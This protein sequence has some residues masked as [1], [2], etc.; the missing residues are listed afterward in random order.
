LQEGAQVCH[1]ADPQVPPSLSIRG[2][3]PERLCGWGRTGRQTHGQPGHHAVCSVPPTGALCF[4]GSSTG[5]PKHQSAKHTKP[6]KAK[7]SGELLS[8]IFAD[9]R[10]F[11]TEKKKAK[12][13]E[14]KAQY[15]NTKQTNENG[16]IKQK[17]KRRRK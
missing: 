3:C 11:L 17:E 13:S 12:S 15:I 8:P 10:R 6:N 2:V 1:Q 5:A 4:L 7:Q 16:E 9:C 14:Q